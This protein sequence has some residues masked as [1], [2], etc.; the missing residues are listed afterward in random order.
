[1]PVNKWV[2]FV[3]NWAA[4]SN[5]SYPCAM[6]DP[7]VKIAYEESKKP[8]P[9]PMPVAPAKKGKGRPKKM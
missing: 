9:A 8:K 2:Q 3:K 6:S 1:M 4:E 5:M 7:Q